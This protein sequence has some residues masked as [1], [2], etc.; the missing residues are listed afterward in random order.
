ML[1][2]WNSRTKSDYTVKSYSKIGLTSIWDGIENEG[3]RKHSDNPSTWNDLVGGNVLIPYGTGIAYG[4]TYVSI[5]PSRTCYFLSE[6]NRILDGFDSITVEFVADA[7][8]VT[9]FLVCFAFRKNSSNN[10]IHFNRQPN[11]ILVPVVGTGESGGISPDTLPQFDI[12]NTRHSCLT[13]DRNQNVVFYTNG[14]ETGT[15]SLINFSNIVNMQSRLGICIVGDWGETYVNVGTLK[16]Y[17]MR[18]Y[19]RSLTAS[20]IAANYAVDKARFGLT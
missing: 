9:G 17:C 14:T 3:F 10:R 6:S 8:N 16:I 13:V 1:K 15:A 7:S 19:N 2:A 12:S 5:T 4:D 11:D 20:E 18:I